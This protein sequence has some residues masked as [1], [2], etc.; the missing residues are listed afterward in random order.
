MPGKS[1]IKIEEQCP[2]TSFILAL[3][4]SLSI[5]VLPF[6]RYLGAILSS[7]K[8]ILRLTRNM[9]GSQSFL[10][11]YSTNDNVGRSK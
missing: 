3:L 4:P 7:E 8:E 5:N 1:T 9:R 11:P 6:F 2:L 10:I